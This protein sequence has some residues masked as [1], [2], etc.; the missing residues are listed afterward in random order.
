[1]A[2]TITELRTTLPDF[3]G[4]VA[5]TLRYSRRNATVGDAH[6]LCSTSDKSARPGRC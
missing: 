6:P 5:S 2:V 1:M 3:V 4:A